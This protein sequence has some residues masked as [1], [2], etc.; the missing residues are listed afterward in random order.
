MVSVGTDIDVT[1]GFWV[2]GDP[3]NDAGVVGTVDG[4]QTAWP[5]DVPDWEYSDGNN[6]RYDPTLT[7]TGNSNIEISVSILT[8]WLK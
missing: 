2:I 4:S 6:W 1:G 3:A 8:V 5:Q 7:V